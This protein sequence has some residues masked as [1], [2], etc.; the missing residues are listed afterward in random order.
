MILSEAINKFTADMKSRHVSPDHL[1]R[2]KFGLDLLQAKLGHR[3][4]NTITLSDLMGWSEELKKA[5]GQ[6]YARASKAGIHRSVKSL[7]RYAKKK[8]LVKK[9]TAKKLPSLSYVPVRD[10]A[11]PPQHLQELINAVPRFIEHRH[12][13]YRD[14]RDAL[15]FLLTLDSTGRRGEIANI[16]RLEAER[17]LKYPVLAEYTDAA[18][19]RREGYVYTILTTGKTEDTPL[20]ILQSTADVVRLW[21]THL[22]PHCVYLMSNI[23]TG[24]PLNIRVLNKAFERLCDF[25]QIPRYYPHAV[26]RR[27]ITDIARKDTKTASR[28]A[29]HS[30]PLTTL[31]HYVSTDRSQVDSAAL[32]LAAGRGRLENSLADEFFAHL[33]GENPSD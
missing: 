9:N 12:G 7:W 29:G 31:R 3:E 28:T 26:R 32:S 27:N 14:V 21:L 25:A 15:I 22:P 30:D 13:R 16:E 4:I 23:K 6:R 19:H 33:T 10:R 17:A 20:T 11:I 8:G 1:R 2:T 5:N 24:K 18:G